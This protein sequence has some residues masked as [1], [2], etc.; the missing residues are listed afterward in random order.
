MGESANSCSPSRRSGR[1]CQ[2][3]DAKTP[4]DATGCE[5]VNLAGPRTTKDTSL[6]HRVSIGIVLRLQG[7]KPSKP[8]SRAVHAALHGADCAAA[9]LRRLLVGKTRG[10][11]QDQGLALVRRQS[12]ERG[13]E[14]LQ[15]HV[16]DLA[17]KRREPRRHSTVGVLHLA[18]AL[19][20]L[21]VE[22]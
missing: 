5:C 7:Q 21:R 2:S 3:C 17:W 12:A 8:M 20:E 15:V 9:D 11:D 10:A 16:A 13:T 1:P 6:R 14:V 18:S 22:G 19:A 4:G